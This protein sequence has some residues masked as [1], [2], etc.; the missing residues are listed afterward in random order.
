MS[1]M[2]SIRDALNGRLQTL[3]AFDAANCAWPGAPY[4]EK[5][6]TPHLRPQI[7]GLT[8]VVSSLGGSKI[9]RWNGIF[10]I[11]AHYPAGKG[12]DAVE[13]RLD[14]LLEHFK[15]G[16]AYAAAG[17]LDPGVRVLSSA[18]QPAVP[19]DAQWIQG[20]VRVSF[21]ADQLQT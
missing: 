17:L 12:T 16:D 20:I 11:A 18:P 3:P 19:Q 15:S 5:P 9:L 13:K 14:D 21:F 4:V 1:A 8:R 2:V 6:G 7:V 10:Q